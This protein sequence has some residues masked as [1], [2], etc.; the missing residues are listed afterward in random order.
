M[1]LYADVALPLPLERTFTYSVPPELEEKA[2]VGIR[3]L[4]PFGPRT[5]TGFVVALR[6][7]KPARGMILRPVAEVLDEAALFSPALLSFSGKLSRYYLISWGEVLQAAVPPTFI[8]RSRARVTLTDR[9]RAA[10]DTETLSGAEGEVASCLSEKPRSLRFLKEK[11]RL[12]NP[13]ALVGRMQKDGLLEVEK[14]V[15]RVRRR[16]APDE[17]K[18]PAQL[19]LDFSLDESLERAAAAAL[20]AVAGRQSSEWL[21]FGSPER[22]DPVYFR[23]IREVLSAGGRVLYLIPEIALTPAVIEKLRRRL[24]EKAAV[25]HSR[26]TDRQ[27]EL[28]WRKVREARAE[29]VVGTRPALFAPVDD[30][31]LIILDE[32]HDESYSQQEGLP[33]D[34]RKAAWLRAREEKATLVYGSAMPTVERFYRAEKGGRLIDL[35]IETPHPRTV[36]VDSRKDSGVVSS[37]LRL[38]IQDR[39]N[40]K[41]PIL[42]FFNRR[43][44]ASHLACARCGF[45]PRCDRCDLALSYHKRE[46]K[47]VCHYCRKS[48]PASGVCPR[49]DSRLVVRRGMGVEALAEALK[50]LFPRHRVEVFATDEASRKEDQERIID[51][52]SSGDIDILAGTQ[53]LAHQSGL[54]PVSLVGLLHPE[55]VLYLAD[56]RSGQKTYQ[57]VSRAFR[58]LRPGTD[59]EILIQTADPAHFSIREAVRGDYRAFYRQEIRYRR[60]LDYPPFSSLAEVVFQ[61]TNLRRVAAA[62][63]QFAGRVR[64][65]GDKV[66]VLGPS[67]APVSK[68]RGRHRIQVILKCRSMAEL[69]GSLRPGLQGIGTKRSLLFIE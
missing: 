34:I 13:S 53:L 15:K 55:T 52:F 8:L 26:M 63:R 10:L 65:L 46:G 59:S 12:K 9:G 16:I 66:K 6:R 38:A 27:R 20:D 56:F 7:K 5:L 11:C 62:A 14:E 49:C 19:E 25:L 32:E 44:Y 30:V 64:S 57:A 43:G 69:A 41:E 39:L 61:G 40:R 67:L 35:S 48:V 54:P 31:R 18:A 23:L 42:L 4:V 37:R 36:V 28:E 17:E 60:L 24:G 45:V 33:F 29:V 22:R 47:F 1:N 3:V 58:F 21:F 2:K 51:R 50:K 68:M